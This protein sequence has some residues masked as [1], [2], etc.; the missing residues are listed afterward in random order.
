MPGHGATPIFGR[1]AWP[2]GGGVERLLAGEFR[3]AKYGFRDCI[4]GIGG[5]EALSEMTGKSPESLEEMF[6]PEGDPPARELFDV[7]VCL[8]RHEGLV[9]KVSS[10]PGEV[11]LIDYTADPENDCDDDLA[12]G[13]ED[14]YEGDLVAGH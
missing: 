12:G 5:F 2:G 1:T 4:A 14:D 13:H 10:E 11:G 6:G 7:L 8:Q 3:L 9:I